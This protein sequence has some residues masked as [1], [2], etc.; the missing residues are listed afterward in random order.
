MSELA[1]PKILV[2]DD[3]ELALVVMRRLLEAENCV[4]DVSSSPQEALTKLTTA[5]YD[6]ILCD[7]WMGEM[8]GKEFY[9]QVR[10]DFP[11]YVRRII[12]VTGDLASEATWEFIDERHLPYI[13]KPFSRPELR[14]RLQEVVGDKLAAA[15]PERAAPPP[16]DGVERRKSRRFT[17]RGKVRVRRKKWAVGQ[18]EVW[19]V[20]NASREGIFF[21]ADRQYRVG[22]EVWVAFPFTG[23]DDD[24][25]QEGFVARLEELPEGRW[26]IVV[27]MGEAAEAAR[28]KFECSQEDARRHHILVHTAEA[29]PKAAPVSVTEPDAARAAQ[30]EDEARRLAEELAQLKSTHV[31]IVDQRDRLAEQESTLKTEL[32]E[33]STAKSAM[34]SYISDLQTKM[35]T[36]EEAKAEGEEYRF[37]ATHDSLTGVW[38]RAAIFDVLKRELLRAQREGTFVGVLLADLDFF[39]KINDVYG[40]LAGDVVLREVAGRIV[41]AVRTYDAVG[42][43]GGEEF[44]IVLSGCEEEPIRHAER[45]RALV[46]AEPVV[47]REG[48]ITVT[49]SLGAAISGGGLPEIEDLLRAADAAMYRAKHAGRNRV[50]AASVSAS[51][52]NPSA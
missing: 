34:T 39:K 12:F 1:P 40:H 41:A 24:I 6:A 33:L 8:T 11:D 38:N 14:R 30:M 42:R 51:A 29:P 43:Y 22:T 36:L 31:R 7:M 15:A 5:N 17:V 48:A 4:A 52:G 2:I 37:R 21:V 50:E 44:L 28:V 35:Q 9:Q 26:G 10:K 16:W 27:A 45:I 32:E 46:S 47:T 13:L 3:D 20:S 18:P 23:R 19:R 49:L 25:E